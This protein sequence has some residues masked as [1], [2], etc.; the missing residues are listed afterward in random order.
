L[1]ASVDTATAKDDEINRLRDRYKSRMKELC[2]EQEKAKMRE[3]KLK[4][5]FEKAERSWTVSWDYQKDK[6]EK[7]AS[8]KKKLENL[9]HEAQERE[10]GTRGACERR[11]TR[12]EQVKYCRRSSCRKYRGGRRRL[13]RSW[14]TSS[15]VFVILAREPESID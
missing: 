9:L 2:K 10:V 8:E 5:D 3:K 6:L 11:W 7:A 12:L 4:R 14:I 1:K 15:S 13:L